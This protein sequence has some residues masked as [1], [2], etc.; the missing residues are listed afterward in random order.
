MTETS[1]GPPPRSAQATTASAAARLA[2]GRRS[3]PS[4]WW[5]MVLFL[6]SEVTI[7]GTMIGSYFYLD[8]QNR[9]W[10]PNH[11]KP[12]E[13]T[14]PVIATAVLLATVPMMVMAER[15]A[16]RANRWP[17]VRWIALAA[18]IQTGYL[19]AQVLLF[20]H[21][22]NTF[23]PQGSAYGSI[24]F[25]LLAAHHAHVLL[26]IVLDLAVLWK[27]VTR[28]LDNYW[29]IGV[30]GVAL[31]WYVVAPL[32]VVVLLTVLSPSL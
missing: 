10:P 20:R 31:Y 28:G 22:L 12:P 30:R 19:A 27:L 9:H 8:F 16:R 23:T 2:R 5:G 18:V 24:Y 11:I 4:G 6:C 26:G 3:Q 15:S 29:L 21:D 14:A 1:A 32:G 25:T 7:F 13:V 17:A